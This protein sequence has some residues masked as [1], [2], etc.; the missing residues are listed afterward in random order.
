MGDL[1]SEALR[2]SHSPLLHLNQELQVR[3]ER[4]HFSSPDNVVANSLEMGQISDQA[5][6]RS[7]HRV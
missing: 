5:S 2:Y 6:S 1:V 3:M 4:S 7:R